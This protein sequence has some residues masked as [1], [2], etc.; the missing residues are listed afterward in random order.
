MHFV[1]LPWFHC[2]DAYQQ[3]VVHQALIPQEVNIESQDIEEL[4]R[5]RLGHLSQ[6]RS[7]FTGSKEVEVLQ[8]GR[9]LNLLGDFAVHGTAFEVKDV[10]QLLGVLQSQGVFHQHDSHS[11]LIFGLNGENSKDLSYQAIWVL[12]EVFRVFV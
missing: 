10:F 7:R 11:T 12:Q 8:G 9:G 1:G 3:R 6:F 4:L 5:F 2:L